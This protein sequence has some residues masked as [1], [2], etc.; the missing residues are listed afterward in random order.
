MAGSKRELL[1]CVHLTSLFIYDRGA[2]GNSGCNRQLARLALFDEIFVSYGP[3][4]LRSLSALV[5]LSVGAAVTVSFKTR[6]LE[7]LQ[8]LHVVLQT[9]DP[10]VC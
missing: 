8:W 10:M 3:N 9:V 6:I 1:R 7:R 2:D 5:L 4:F